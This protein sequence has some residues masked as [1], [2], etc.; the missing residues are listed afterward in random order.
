MRTAGLS[1]PLH[2]GRTRISSRRG[3]ESVCFWLV[4]I[5]CLAQLW[6]LPPNGHMRGAAARALTLPSDAANSALV[7]FGFGARQADIRCSWPG[8]SSG[9]QN[10]NAPASGRHDTCPCCPLGHAIVGILPPEGMSVRLYSAFVQDR[11]S[12]PTFWCVCEI[13]VL[14]RAASR[15]SRPD[16]IHEHPPAPPS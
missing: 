11:H 7:T 12:A 3:P 1:C 14:R 10:G 16:L 6:G 2:C 5:A 8:L 15:A 13:L 9:S 4:L